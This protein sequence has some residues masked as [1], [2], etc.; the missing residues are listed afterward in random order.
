MDEGIQRV[1]NQF[2]DHEAHIRRLWHTDEDFRDLCHEYALCQDTL[3]RWS[4]E[5]VPQV[6]KAEYLSLRQRLEF[7]IEMRLR[8]FQS[9]QG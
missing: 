5:M 8:D 4:D 1:I 6:R 9:H 3:V 7:E 2:S